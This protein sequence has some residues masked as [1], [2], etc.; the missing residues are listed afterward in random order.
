MV[1]SVRGQIIRALTYRRKR[2]GPP[3]GGKEMT[4]VLTDVEDSTLIWEMCPTQMAQVHSVPGCMDVLSRL[5]QPQGS[6][7]LL[8]APRAAC[9]NGGPC[10]AWVLV[11]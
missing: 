4:L 2:L 9:P 11:T 8:L 6:R 1:Y 10:V 3:R 5:A 7:G